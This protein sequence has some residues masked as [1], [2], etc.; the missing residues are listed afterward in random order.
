ME[1]II[2]IFAVFIGIVIY[3]WLNPG[4]REKLKPSQK[5]DTY[6]PKNFGEHPDILKEDWVKKKKEP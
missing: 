4:S 6:E 3:F 1:W 2:I 5:E